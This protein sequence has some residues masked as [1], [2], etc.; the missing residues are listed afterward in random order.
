M[1]NDIKIGDLVKLNFSL[2]DKD[3]F[4]DETKN[5]GIVVGKYEDNCGIKRFDV[6]WLKPYI[7]VFPEEESWVVK[8]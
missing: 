6:L 3:L 7:N 2:L 4:P 8:I 5:I 1:S